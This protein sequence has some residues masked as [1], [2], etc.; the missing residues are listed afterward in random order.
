MVEAKGKVLSLDEIL[1]A[2]DVQVEEVEIPEWGGSVLVRG[3]SGTQRDRFEASL[4]KGK[5][6]NREVNLENFRAKLVAA[7]VVDTEG[8]LVFKEEHIPAIGRKS[9]R[10]LARIID[11]AN[12]LSG[13]SEDDVEQLTKNSE[14]ETPDTTNG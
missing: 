5:G 9:A 7:S 10:A 13:I 6:A 4:Q 12:K 8:R 3:M 11:V 14:G 1:G 2:Q